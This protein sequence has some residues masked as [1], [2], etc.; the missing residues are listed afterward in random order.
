MRDAHRGIRLVD[1]LA[2][3]A[4]RAVGVHL[5][6]V[7][8]DL[9]LARLLDDGRDLDAGERRLAAVGAVEGRQPHQPVDALLRRVEA[10]GVLA[11]DA[12][13][14]GLDARLL[15]GG[16]LEQLDLEAAPLRPAHLHAQDHLRPVLRV[17]PAGAGVDGH[18]RVAG[19]VL[20]AEQPLLL[21]L[22]EPPLDRLE[23]LV[24]LGRELGILLREL[25]Q[26]LEVVRV[27]GEPREH[28]E[29]PLCA[30]VLGAD[31]RGPLRLVPEP[32]LA[33]LRLER[34][35]ALAQRRRVKGSPRAGTTARGW[36]PAAAAW[37]GRRWGRPWLRVR[38]AQ[39]RVGT[40][41]W[42]RR[43]STASM[44]P[45]ATGSSARSCR[46]TSAGCAVAGGSTR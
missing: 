38:L 27:G 32:G 20:A 6:V 21:Q 24:E 15:S 41:P 35:Q 11:G 7:V 18:Q 8:V 4:G 13:G 17:G 16:G 5:Q 25:G 3:G 9:D 34:A 12:E 29:A 1:V 10:V 31:A 40:Q 43:C 46:I 42:A 28:V 22:A 45:S 37:A 30:R 33:H 26:P 19:V 36:R 2:A 39:G 14:G 44:P 23:R